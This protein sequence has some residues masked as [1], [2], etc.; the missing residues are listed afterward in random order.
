MSQD[1]TAVELN[2][3]TGMGIPESE[4]QD[5]A[6]QVLKI[7]PEVKP[8]VK[9]EEA[10]PAEK[11]KEEIKEARQERPAQPSSVEKAIFS[12]LKEMRDELKTLKPAEKAEAKEV[13]DDITALA[14]K[15]GLD[16]EGLA[17]IAEVLEKS[18]LGKLETTG[19]LSKDLPTDVQDKLKQ[20]DSI[21]ADK[22]A[23]DEA[24]HFEKEWLGV[25]PDL[26]KQYPNAKAGELAEAKKILDEISHSKEHHAHDLDYI[27]FKEKNKFETILKVAKNSKSGETSS[28]QIADD[29][30]ITLDL[31]PEEMTPEKAKAYEL[32]RLKGSD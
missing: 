31:N 17:E 32:R 14:E 28:K 21:L 29:S 12:Q 16:K 13:I 24:D 10:K 19:K 15:R 25:L 11:P 9:A 2:N 6:P 7:Q 18:I 20:L 4:T 1:K 8:E 22:K 30:D 26:Q 23:R 3:L 27:L 5:E